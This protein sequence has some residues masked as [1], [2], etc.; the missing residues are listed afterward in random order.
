MDNINMTSGNIENILGMQW[1]AVKDKFVF[2]IKFKRVSA[3]II[4]NKRTPTKR[5]VLRLIMSVFDPFGFL[6][7]F[8][9]TGKIFM[10]SLWRC[11]LEWDEEIPEALRDR[12]KSWTTG[13]KK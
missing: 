13:L 8:T 2:D 9:I 6:S 7:N 11:G 4:E 3:D 5:E 1:S 12:W 10:Q